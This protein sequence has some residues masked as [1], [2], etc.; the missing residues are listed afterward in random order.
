M[1]RLAY[2]VETN[3]MGGAE[4]YIADLMIAMGGKGYEIT[5]VCNDFRP[6]VDYIRKRVG[7]PMAPLWF[8]SVSRS[9]AIQSGL[10]VNRKMRGRLKLLKIPGLVVYYAYFAYAFFVLWR[11]WG[12][13]RPDVLHVSAGG[14]PAGESPRAAVLA[15]RAR[16]IPR[17][18]MTVHN[19][20][21][22]PPPLAFFERK[23]DRAVERSLHK[24]V[25]VSHSS[26]NSLVE[27]RGF[28]PDRVGVIHNGYEPPAPGGATRQKIR[29]ELGIPLD[30]A[31]VGSVG[32]LQP[33]KGYHVLVN[34][35]AQMK[36]RPVRL[37]VIG[38]G[39][40]RDDLA[41]Q[42]LEAGLSDRI[43]WAGFRADASRCLAAFDVFAFPSTAFESFPYVILEAMAAGLPVAATSVGGT[44][45]Q[46]QDGVSGRLV[47]PDNAAALAS[48]L[49]EILD[50]P[51]LGRAW[52]EAARKRVR[53]NFS[54]NLMLERTEALYHE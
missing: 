24:L 8:P 7:A 52:G 2:F 26:K 51:A 13:L 53:E 15:A 23:I 18:V 25:C 17:R 40:C 20:A 34:A 29:E 10:A 31:V 49:D 14:Y 30:A 21:D 19:L 6:L 50:D 35:L 16:G 3:A 9:R 45:E 36:R 33:R 4:K 28:N 11:L 47:P 43:V 44:V 1:T 22:A 54:M 12:R 27:K 37:V 48:A 32:G 5:F 41:R 39:P 46:I 38:D 42:A